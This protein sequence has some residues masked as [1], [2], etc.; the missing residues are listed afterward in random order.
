MADKHANGARIVVKLCTNVTPVQA[1]DARARALRYAFDR[2]LEKQKAAKT[3]GGEDDKLDL[4]P[5]DSEGA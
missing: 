4:R 2:Y 5:V 1:R 3:S